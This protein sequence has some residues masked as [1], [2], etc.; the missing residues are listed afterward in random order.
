MWPYEEVEVTEIG[1]TQ[2][3]RLFIYNP[4]GPAMIPGSRVTISILTVSETFQFG[5]LKAG[6]F[7]GSLRYARTVPQKGRHCFKI[8]CVDQ[9]WA[10]VC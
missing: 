10:L 3:P 2:T 5:V 7:P 6:G 8:K 1:F 4:E 9:V